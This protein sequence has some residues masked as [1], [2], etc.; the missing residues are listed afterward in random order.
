MKEGKVPFVS[1]KRTAGEVKRYRMYRRVVPVGIGVV[2]AFLTLLYVVSVLFQRY[3]SFTV[4]VHEY[5]DRRYGL[6]LSEQDSFA[7]PT[8]RLNSAAAKD[9][10]NI[11]GE[12]DLPNN[13]NDSGGEHNGDNYIAYTFF[14]KNTGENT[15]TYQYNLTITRQTTG[16]AAAARVRLY[17]EPFYYDT[18][19]GEY[20]Y[21]NTYTDYAKPKTGG[22]GAPEVDGG[23]TMTN[24]ADENTVAIGT[25]PDFKP[26]D[27][28]KITVVVWLEGNDPDCTDDVLGGQFKLD[29]SFDIVGAGES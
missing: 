21:T 19:T 25:V 7:N 18:D 6:S 22:G 16:I 17:F 3:G 10:T 2:V 20:R 29:M 13:L 12:K 5:D 23:R 11:D 14:V 4:K 9:I 28:S 27:I 1:V 8:S 24:F 26:G 15:C